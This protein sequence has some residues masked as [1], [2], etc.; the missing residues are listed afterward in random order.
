MCAGT[1]ARKEVKS[2]EEKEGK[3]RAGALQAT[4]ESTQHRCWLCIRNKTVW[5]SDLEER[6]LELGCCC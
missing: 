4:Y 6:Y 3:T 1:Q 2:K 5:G